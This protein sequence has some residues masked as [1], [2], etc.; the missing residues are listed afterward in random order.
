MPL[1]TDQGICIRQWDWSETSQTV[2]I[3]ARETGVIRAIAK[4]SKRE[5]SRFSGGIE[6][7]TRAEVIANIKSTE[8]LTLLT[9]WDL[10]ETFP[11]ARASLSAFYAGMSMLELIHHG[12]HE[13]DPHPPLFEALLAALRTLGVPDAAASGVLT[14]LW[15]VLTETGHQPEI[16][17]DVVTTAALA[18]AR[19]YTFNS[20]LGG[21]T[22]D[23]STAVAGTFRV[24]TETVEV[25]RAVAAGSLVQAV[26]PAAIHR[27]TR[28]LTLYFQEVF[29]C[30]LAAMQ[31]WLGEPTPTGAANE[32]RR[33]VP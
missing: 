2:S 4:G 6:V 16:Q 27:A 33:S 9:A 20:R 8:G 32:P 17:R 28:L 23:Q 22:K 5:N 15:T 29:S 21:L 10:Q 1:I 31:Q 7:M 24:R 26:E 13:H 3:F 18:P 11:A 25:L 14:L 19:A 30:E 12:L